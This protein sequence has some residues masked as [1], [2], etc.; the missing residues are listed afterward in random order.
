MC[1]GWEDAG[2]HEAPS[3]LYSH[4]PLLDRDTSRTGFGRRL[5]QLLAT[6]EAVAQCVLAAP[7]QLPED[8]LAR[9]ISEDLVSLRDL[10]ERHR[11]LEHDYESLGT[12]HQRTEDRLSEK[13]EMLQ[14]HS[15]RLGQL[16]AI[17]E[18]SEDVILSKDLNGI[19][20]SWN[21]AAT[22]LIGYSREELIYQEYLRP[23][24]RPEALWVQA[25]AC[26]WQSSLL[27]AMGAG[28]RL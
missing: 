10:K 19:I 8:M 12:E 7:A 18:S 14:E 22:R 6:H 21:D 27:K 13:E 17:V 9:R 20:T 23:S 16:A 25:L 15:K 4:S 1:L 2:V 26:L 5:K 28:S 3:S 24:S 11:R